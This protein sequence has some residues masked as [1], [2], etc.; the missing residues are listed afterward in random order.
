MKLIGKHQEPASS[1]VCAKC[2]QGHH[3]H[4]YSNR[5]KCEVCKG[6]A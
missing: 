2:R 5:C 1:F 6:M 3:H 4:C